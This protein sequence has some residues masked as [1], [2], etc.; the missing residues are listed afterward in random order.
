MTDILLEAP[1]ITRRVVTYERVSSDDQRERQ[2]ILLQQAALA[3]ELE[4]HPECELV[5][6][7]VDDGVSG[8]LPFAKRPDGC[9]LMRDA[10]LGRFD[11]VLVYDN[12]RL[13]RDQ[14]DP[15]VVR[16][17]LEY[18]GVRLRSLHEGYADGLL[19]PITV[20]IADEERK[21]FLRRSA[22]GMDEAAK[23][24]RYCGGIVPYG[25]RAEGHKNTSHLVP[26]EETAPGA[27]MSE[28]EVVR[29]IYRRLAADGWSC[30]RVADELNDLGVRTKYA[31]EGRGVRGH[32]TQGR[33]GAGRIHAMVTNP[34]YRGELLYGRRSEKKREVVSARVEPLVSEEIWWAAQETLAR[35]R[36]VAKNTPR[37]YLL[38]GVLKCAHCGRNFCGTSSHGES[39]YRCDGS[40]QRTDL[41][42]ERCTAKRVKGAYLEPVVWADIERFLRDP[43]DVLAEL[44]RESAGDPTQ[45]RLLEERSRLE[46]ALDQRRDERER[47]LDLYQHGDISRPEFEQRAEQLREATGR[48]KERL[49]ALASQEVEHDEQLVDPDL[50]AE[51]RR[52]L[53]EGQTPE[54]RQEIIRLLVRDIIVH[55]D[56]DHDGNK[57]Q[58]AV[59]RYRFDGAV[60]SRTDTGSWRPRA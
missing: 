44:Q 8:T 51:L 32:R 37:I 59:I 5:C 7:Y 1:A 47:L 29:H 46:A 20:A 25:Y 49:A 53:D 9:R 18:L 11:E 55:A 10:E 39:W 33:W 45:E 36:A 30:R 57:T 58:R 28:A 6:R 4:A 3:R 60:S 48:I 26:A 40:L 24:G 50:M 19:F 13:G 34:V 14:I 35:N 43:G 23:Q 41:V 42:G 22:A 2:T 27:L 38:R 17:E 56:V 54:Q 31:L 21:T 12:S 52:R 15:L 16:R